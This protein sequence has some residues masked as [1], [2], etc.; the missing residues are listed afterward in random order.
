VNETRAGEPGTMAAS[1]APKT[2]PTQ[3]TAP[4]SGAPHDSAPNDNELALEWTAR[5]RWIL[6]IITLIVAV[7]VGIRFVQL[8][9]WRLRPLEVS[10][11]ESRRYEFQLEIN[12]A[13]W[14]EWMQLEGIGEA[15]ARKIIEDRQQN[16]P[17]RSIHDVAR[18]KGIGPATLEKIRPWLRLDPGNESTATSKGPETGP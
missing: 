14:V 10:R 12:S 17:F 6:A 4:A 11:P 3:T 2:V 7:L 5:D 16:G 15:T 18:V 13:S 1:A 9:G 8:S